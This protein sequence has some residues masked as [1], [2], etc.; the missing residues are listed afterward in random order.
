VLLLLLLLQSNKALDVLL[1]LEVGR[2]LLLLLLLLIFIFSS[3]RVIL[4]IWR[5]SQLQG[6]VATTEQPWQQ[7]KVVKEGLRVTCYHHLHLLA[8]WTAGSSP[9]PLQNVCQHSLLTCCYTC[10][11]G[12]I[13][14]AMAAVLAGQT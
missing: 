10:L 5:S 13:R 3:R 9:T 12:S 14:I 11:S 1:I 7:R 4:C 8:N 6:T 2:L